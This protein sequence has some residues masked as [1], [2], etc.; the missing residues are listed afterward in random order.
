MTDLK[1]WWKYRRDY[2]SKIFVSK[3][4]DKKTV[5]KVFCVI[6]GQNWIAGC[7][8]EA[9]SYYLGLTWERSEKEWQQVGNGVAQN[10]QNCSYYSLD[11]SPPGHPSPSWHPWS[12][13]ARSMFPQHQVK[14]SLLH[15][16]SD[17]SIPMVRSDPWRQH[18]LGS[19]RMVTA[20]L[21]H[22]NRE[23]WW[24]LSSLDLL[25]SFP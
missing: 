19:K 22:H 16:G 11:P 25:G 5:R 17:F 8:A 3:S 23:C 20:L 2:W 7:W 13:A 21:V 18:Q 14:V 1:Q 10:E 24:A 6:N 4:K 15:G 12:C 9:Q